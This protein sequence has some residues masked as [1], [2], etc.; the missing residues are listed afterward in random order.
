MAVQQTKE[1]TISIQRKNLKKNFIL[2][3]QDLRQTRP[4]DLA[5]PDPFG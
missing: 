2:H 3:N 5:M 1:N 4:G